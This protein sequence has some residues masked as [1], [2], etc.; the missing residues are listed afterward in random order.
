M[1]EL[2]KK[3]K[4]FLSIIETSTM[5]DKEIEMLINAG[6]QELERSGVNVNYNKK[7]DTYSDL[8]NTAI[9][10]FVK[11]NFGNVDIKEKEL[12]HRTFN[13]LEQSLSQSFGYKKEEE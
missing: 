7:E 8:V 13:N 11:S 9:M 6:I 5:K 1:N 3:A 2:L 12:A 10:F 4:Q